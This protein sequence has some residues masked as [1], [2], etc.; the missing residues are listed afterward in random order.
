MAAEDGP[1]IAMTTDI[2]AL[3]ADSAV[4]A[5]LPLDASPPTYRPGGKDVVFVC[6]EQMRP[7]LDAAA[8]RA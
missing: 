2:L 4:R 8:Q 3:M 5:G 7:V 6:V 1:V